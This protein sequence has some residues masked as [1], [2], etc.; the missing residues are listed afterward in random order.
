MVTTRGP[1][2]PSPP[3]RNGRPDDAQAGGLHSAAGTGE[4]RES[5]F[6]RQLASLFGESVFSYIIAQTIGF[7]MT[8]GIRHDDIIALRKFFGC[9]SPAKSVVCSAVQQQN[10]RFPPAGTVVVDFNSID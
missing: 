9:P 2:S 7:A 1:S 3:N 6:D 4:H 5:G 10:R 8:L